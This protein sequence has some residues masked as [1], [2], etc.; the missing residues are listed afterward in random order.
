MFLR[1]KVDLNVYSTNV[2]PFSC[3]LIGIF[4]DVV[5]ATSAL[6]HKYYTTQ[7]KKKKRKE[8]MFYV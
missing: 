4:I 1:M 3:A 6:L 7:S 8:R 5:V 2:K